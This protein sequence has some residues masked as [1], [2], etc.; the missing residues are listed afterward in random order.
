M[1][2]KKFIPIGALILVLAMILMGV[3]AGAAT[4]VDTGKPA[5]LQ[6]NYSYGQESYQG[7]EIKVYKVATI[8][9]YMDFT[10]TGSFADLPVEVNKIRTQ[11]EWN[12]LASTVTALV[13]SEAIAP[14]ATAQTDE[15]GIAAFPTLSQGL[16]LV[17]GVR[18]EVEGGYR[19]FGSFMISLPDL[20]ENDD[21]VYDVMAKP[22]SVFEEYQY[23]E[24]EL[25]VSKLWKD[26]GKE[27]KRPE[28]V[29]VE[30]YKD[31]VLVETV[32]LS[33]ENNWTY[34]WK[35]LDDGSVWQAVEVNV[36]EGYTMTVQR[37]GNAFVIVNT[38]DGPTPPPQTGD[39]TDIT[40]L[41]VIMCLAGIGLIFMGIMSGRGKKV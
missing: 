10:L 18:V 35:T 30:L 19:D 14:D 36:P 4:M 41:F 2:R 1:M 13:L 7:L 12:Q 39:F 23:E 11:E 27:D 5:S 28:A 21:W 31:S 24:I 9:E 15:S 38:V 20:D 16:Y 34:S 40:L 25:S 32:T 6:L 29:T 17:E 8:S 22:K 26:A 37:S 3:G 33:G